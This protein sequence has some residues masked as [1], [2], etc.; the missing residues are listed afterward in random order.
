VENFRKFILIF[1]E[2]CWLYLCQSA[3]SKS[4]IAKWCCK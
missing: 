2:I 1:R 3:V 4:S